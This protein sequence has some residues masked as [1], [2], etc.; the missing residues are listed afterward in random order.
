MVII[1]DKNKQ[2]LEKKKKSIET[3]QLIERNDK[4]HSKVVGEKT[5]KNH[6]KIIK[7]NIVKAYFQ[8]DKNEIFWLKIV[9]TI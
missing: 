9:R 5:K 7:A 3:E 2:L 6:S 1:I 8:M 4:I